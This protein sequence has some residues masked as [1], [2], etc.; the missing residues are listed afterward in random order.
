MPPPPPPAAPPAGDNT[1]ADH[2]VQYKPAA[3]TPYNFKSK[4]GTG[5]TTA[6]VDGDEVGEDEW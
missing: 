6:V 1:D 3:P 4:N 5:E 2:V